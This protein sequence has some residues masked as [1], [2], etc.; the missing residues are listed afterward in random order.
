MLGPRVSYLFSS[1]LTFLSLRWMVDGSNWMA[2]AT[3]RSMVED[4]DYGGGRRVRRLGQRG[5][6]MSSLLQAVCEHRSV[7]LCEGDDSPRRLGTFSSSPT[8]H[9]AASTSSPLLSFPNADLVLRLDPCP[10]YE[11]DF[12][13]SED[14]HSSIDLHV[15]SVSLLHSHYFGA[16]LSDRWSPAPTSITRR[17]ER[18]LQRG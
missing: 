13:V 18:R 9:A 10:D 3:R 7:D 6:R 1:S 8:P 5:Q 14:H 16:L 2:A 15:S 11:V 12:D 4:E 17:E